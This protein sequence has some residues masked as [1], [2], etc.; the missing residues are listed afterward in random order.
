MFVFYIAI[1]IYT[2]FIYLFIFNT[3]LKHTSIYI[4]M[5]KNVT[6]YVFSIILYISFDMRNIYLPV[7]YFFFL[8]LNLVS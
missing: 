3:I 2:R 5:Y 8:F 1:K 7:Y 4:K 6:V